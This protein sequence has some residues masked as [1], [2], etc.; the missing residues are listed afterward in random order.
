MADQI[1]K[2]RDPQGNLREISGPAGASD[3]DIIAQAQ[4]LFAGPA[5]EKDYRALAK[6]VPVD[7]T[8][9][10]GGMAKFN[11]GMGKAFTDIGQG[12]A[13]L[14]GMGESGAE[15]KDRRALDQPLMKTGA[16]M[17]GNISGNIAALAPLALVP[18][19]GTVAG[20]GALGAV[21]GGVQAAGG[22][23]ERLGNMLSGGALGAGTQAVVG[24][25]ARALGE[26]GARKEA[27]AAARQSQNAVRDQTLREAQAAGYTVPPSSINPS[28]VNKILESIGGRAATTQESSIRN[29]EVTNK[30]ARAALGMPEEQAISEAGLK[31]YRNT[32]A[33]PYR[34]VAALS[35]RAELALE[36]LKEAR[37]N[38]NDY[39]KFYARSGDPSARAAADN[40]AKKAEQAEQALEAAAAKGGKPELIDA[41]RESRK[42]IAKSYDV[43]RALNE[44]SGDVSARM[45]GAALDKGRPLSGELST[46]ARFAEAFPK[47]TQNMA[48]MQAPGVSNTTAIVGSLLGAGGASAMGP[49]GVLAGG[50]PM[51]RGPARSIALQMGR[52]VAPDYAVG[53]GTRAAAQLADPET[54]RRVALL[55]RSLMLPAVPQLTGA[56]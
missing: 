12:A 55:A 50:L 47:S 22:V 41:L 7:P 8:E 44:G 31:A 49:A 20:A 42:Q 18:G 34:D 17:A 27:E 39:A 21:A 30:L 43:S 35:T 52:S 26:Y 9:G 15:T 25:G 2:V 48:G 28:P 19:A 3:A 4:K 23:Q 6:P 11:A 38:A 53:A 33:Q 36:Q 32:A 37:F 14:V 24:P 40:F 45:L 5:K 56:E 54:Q 10:M 46:A 13:Q 1:Y 16:G 51:L 29:Q